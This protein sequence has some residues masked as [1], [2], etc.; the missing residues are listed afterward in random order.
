MQTNQS[1]DNER[2]LFNPAP[3]DLP[4]NPVSEA[5]QALRPDPD[6]LSLDLSTRNLGLQEWISGMRNKASRREI[7]LELI[8]FW[9]NFS[10]VLALV[11]SICL[12]AMLAI[13]GLVMFNRLPP[14]IP[15][16]YNS[17]E[18]RWEQ[19]DKAMVLI[20]PIV[21]AVIDLILLKFIFDVFSYDK[22]LG[23]MLSWSMTIVNMLIIIASGQI[24][25]LI[26]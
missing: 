6:Q 15:F 10:S 5:S 9:R 12:V 19:G 23:L 14:R 8:P 7:E 20:I 4:A 17:V 21:L 13:L 18:A 22:R 26:L 3:Q 16:Y 24:Y 25:S 11:S 2:A 1:A